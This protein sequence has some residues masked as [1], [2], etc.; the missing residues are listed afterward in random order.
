MDFNNHTHNCE[1]LEELFTS[2]DDAGEA[3]L[4]FYRQMR[5][6]LARQ[7]RQKQKDTTSM[8]AR[9]RIAIQAC[10]HS[11]ITLAR[12]AE[13]DEFQPVTIEGTNQAFF[14]ILRGCF[15]YVF[16]K[17]RAAINGI[18]DRVKSFNLN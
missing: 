10:G 17:H 14:G 6:T 1:V 18:W 8:E 3:G 13:D 16:S 7:R 4:K 9:F 5:R 2:C 15:T 12:Y 11:V